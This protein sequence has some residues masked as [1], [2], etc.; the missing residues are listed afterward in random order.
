MLCV[1]SLHV[2]EATGG[3]FNALVRLMVKC[4]CLEVPGCCST[5]TRYEVCGLLGCCCP[6][7]TTLL[8]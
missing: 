1:L 3:G 5:T 2:T 8:C 7:G 6:L 4:N